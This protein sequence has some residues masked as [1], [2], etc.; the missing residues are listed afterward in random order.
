MALIC[1]DLDGTLLDPMEGLLAS[2]GRSCDEMGATLPPSGEIRRMVGLDLRTLFAEPYATELLHRCWRYFEEEGLFAQRA[3]D[4]IHLMLAR[5]KRQGHRLH[6][7]TNQPATCARKAL[8]HFDLN[9]VFDGVTGLL[10]GETWKPK[11]EIMTALHQ[12]GVLAR[13][14]LLIGDRADDLRAAHGYGLHGVGLTCGF[15]TLAELEE[16][17][18]AVILDSIRDLDLWLGETLKDPEVHD[19]FSRSE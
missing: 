16:A 12:E 8:H 2:L 7:V 15:G 10:P 13:G 5:L 6:L 17:E 18:P 1:I 19:P 14:G 3:Q 9:L 4:G 11:I